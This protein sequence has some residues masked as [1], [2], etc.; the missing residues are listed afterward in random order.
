MK[1]AAVITFCVTKRCQILA[2]RGSGAVSAGSG[3]YSGA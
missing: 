2:V 1:S 3:V